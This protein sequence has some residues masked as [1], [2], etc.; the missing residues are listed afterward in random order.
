[1]VRNGIE[2]SIM[3]AIAEC[4]EL[5]TGIC[6]LESGAVGDLLERW[7]ASGRAS[8]FLLEITAEIARTRDPLAG[9]Y[10]LAHVS[11]VAGQKGAGAWSVEAGLTYGVPVPSIMEA[12]NA[13]Q[14][15]GQSQAR[16][17]VGQAAAQSHRQFLDR[18]GRR[19]GSND[20]RVAVPGASSLCGGS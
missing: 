12:V 9:G 20:D 19:P 1:M 5:L 18:Y 17:G 16:E 13:R 11:D 3:Q 8:G 14:I 6:G 2:Y 7:N 10:L 4:H 15:S